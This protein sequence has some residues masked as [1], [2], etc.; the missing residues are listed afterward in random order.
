MAYL[1]IQG[2]SDVHVSHGL[3]W[4]SKVLRNASHGAG[5]VLVVIVVNRVRQDT[6]LLSHSYRPVSSSLP[7]LQLPP[8]P[9]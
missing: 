8:T 9:G 5:G 7:G 1:G 3:S 2:F 6:G 4:E